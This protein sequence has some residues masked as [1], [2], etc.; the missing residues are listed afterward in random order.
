[1]MAIIMAM[2]HLEGVCPAR[3]LC[4]SRWRWWCGCW[5]R[6][7]WR[8]WQGPYHRQLWCCCPS[9]WVW[10][11]K[12]VVSFLKDGP[13]VNI[14]VVDNFSWHFLDRILFRWPP[15]RSLRSWQ[16]RRPP[17]RR[18][19]PLRARCVCFLFLSHK[20]TWDLA[21]SQFTTGGFFLDICNSHQAAEHSH[22][23]MPCGIMDQFIS[24][25]YLV[26]NNKQITRYAVIK[27][28]YK[29]HQ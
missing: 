5:R 22:A 4:S 28:K 2:F 23:G 16:V 27:P 26:F 21:M 3:H 9:E 25:I 24:V 12:T 1:M 6:C 15:I 10:Y 29:Y 7:S 20:L 18:R 8:C 11:L 17:Q 19:K 13:P 14:L